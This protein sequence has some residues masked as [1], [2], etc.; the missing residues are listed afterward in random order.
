MSNKRVIILSSVLLFMLAGCGSDDPGSDVVLHSDVSDEVEEIFE[1][2]LDDDPV[3]I[4]NAEALGTEIDRI[5][6][7]EKRALLRAI[8]LVFQMVDALVTILPISRYA[9]QWALFATR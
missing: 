4:S 2:D 3:G 6:G 1:A 7:G 8:W 5:F 9:Q